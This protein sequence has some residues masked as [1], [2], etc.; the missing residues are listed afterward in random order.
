MSN[1]GLK[2]HLDLFA[3]MLINRLDRDKH[4]NLF[5]SGPGAVLSTEQF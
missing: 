4:S 3:M 2:L 5:E 1:V